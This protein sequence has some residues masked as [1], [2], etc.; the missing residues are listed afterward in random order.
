MKILRY[1]F[2]FIIGLLV[3][4]V[5]L[6]SCNSAMQAYKDG[7]RKYDNGQIDLAIK[8]LKKAEAANYEPVQTDF[9]IAQS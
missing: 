9:L 6:S 8:D 7:V 5:S 1:Y 2:T 4:S 3:I